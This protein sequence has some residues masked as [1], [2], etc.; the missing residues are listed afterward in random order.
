MPLRMHSNSGVSCSRMESLGARRYSVRICAVVISP[1]T[2]RPVW[3]RTKGGESGMSPGFEQFLLIVQ[4]PF[5]LVLAVAR[6]IARARKFDDGVPQIELGA[7]HPRTRRVEEVAVALENRHGH[8]QLQLLVFGL[9]LALLVVGEF[10]L[11]FRLQKQA[12]SES[13]AHQVAHVRN[14]ALV[15]RDEDKVVLEFADLAIRPL[16]LEDLGD[17][18]RRLAQ[19]GRYRSRFVTHHHEQGPTVADLVG[20]FVRT[21][22]GKHGIEFTARQAEKLRE[23]ARQA[24]CGLRQRLCPA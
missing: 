15:G 9:D 4:D 24:R 21:G 12:E 3:S 10:A 19:I 5:H 7:G 8:I 23:C 1:F 13:A 22:R 2:R 11:M 14:G 17:V 16:V 20:H 18:G 6:C